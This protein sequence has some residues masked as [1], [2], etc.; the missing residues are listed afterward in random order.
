MTKI[1]CL[2][3]DEI[4]FWQDFIENLDS[5]EEPQVVERCTHALQFAQY[6]LK[7]SLEENHSQ[8]KVSTRI[9]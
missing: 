7:Q 4:S 3:L 2:L 8:S 1:E 6:R 5:S 9:Q